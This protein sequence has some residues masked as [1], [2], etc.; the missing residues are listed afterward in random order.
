MSKGLEVNS[1]E[2]METLLKTAVDQLNLYPSDENRQ[3]VKEL[4]ENW[5]RRDW[6]IDK[7]INLVSEVRDRSKRGAIIFSSD[8]DANRGQ[9]K[10]SNTLWGFKP[11]WTVDKVI[12]D[13]NRWLESFQSFQYA[14]L[15]FSAYASDWA[16]ADLGFYISDKDYVW[17]SGGAFKSERQGHGQQ[18]DALGLT[19]T[20][21]Y[22]FVLTWC[23]QL[24]SCKAYEQDGTGIADITHRNPPT[25][26]MRLKFKSNGPPSE[27]MLRSITV[28]EAVDP[29]FFLEKGGVPSGVI[30]L[31][32]GA[33][34]DIPTGWSLCDGTG[35]TPDLRDRFV[36]G[37]G[38]TYDPNDTG[39]ADTH[40]HAAPVGYLASNN[41]LQLKGNDAPWGTEGIG[42]RTMEQKGYAWATGSSTVK[43]TSVTDHKPKYYALAYI[44]KD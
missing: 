18:S 32:S 23:P 43:K 5:T 21:D 42:T 44:M 26:E 28:Q 7:I 30:L 11:E 19:N 10:E 33:I 36:L 9:W 40:Q 1:R 38:S 17:V 22:Q 15:C 12:L 4:M 34:V 35:G 31:W 3:A 8:M 27:V 41:Q 13:W 16:E 39:G 25:R 20:K 2:E 37:A 6:A 29:T 24:C 14:V